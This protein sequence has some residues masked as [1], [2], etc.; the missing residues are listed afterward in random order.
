MKSPA[1]EANSLTEFHWLFSDEQPVESLPPFFP[2]VLNFGQS[3]SQFIQASTAFQPQRRS[4]ADPAY[5]EEVGPI[6][7]EEA[8]PIYNP[9][10]PRR[11]HAGADSPVYIPH[12]RSALDDALPLVCDSRLDPLQPVE[13][14]TVIPRCDY[15]LKRPLEHEILQEEDLPPRKYSRV[16]E[17]PSSNPSQRSSYDASSACTRPSTASP[18]MG[19]SAPAGG[20]DYM[21]FEHLMEIQGLRAQLAMSEARNLCA[22]AE[23]AEARTCIDFLL[24]EVRRVVSSTQQCPIAK[25]AER[26]IRSTDHHV[27]LFTRMPMLPINP[28]ASQQA[29]LPAFPSMWRKYC[30][31]NDPG[32]ATEFQPRTLS[33]TSQVASVDGG[34]LEP[35][36]SLGAR[37]PTSYGEA[38]RIPLGEC[39]PPQS[40]S[41]LPHPRRTLDPEGSQLAAQ[42][43]N[44]SR[45]NSYLSLYYTEAAPPPFTE[46]FVGLPQNSQPPT[47][48]SR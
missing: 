46:P 6:S 40:A 14:P 16:S 39:V 21:R 1:Q 41:F 37:G 38:S 18:S 7:H 2:R 23:L 48:S 35:L 36:Q 12:D 33:S 19:Y 44:H 15:S 29:P 3:D 5:D 30:L 11:S 43:S 17:V 10:S 9:D 45:V 28:T 22:V 47:H 32:A 31:T 34:L 26:I 24:N 20:F 13:I 8:S 4:R 42:D 25:K 27:E